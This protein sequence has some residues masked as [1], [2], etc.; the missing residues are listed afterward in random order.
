M[1]EQ[2]KNIFDDYEV[3]NFG[4]LRRKLLTGDYKIINCSIMNRGYKYFQ[5]RRQKKRINC[6]IHVLVAKHFLGEKPEQLVIDHID[7]NKLNNN[8]S[9]LRY[10]SQKVNSFN[11]DRVNQ[12]IEQDDPERKAKISKIYRDN[13]QDILKEKKRNYY[14]K[15]KEQIL[16]K[17]KN[18]KINVICPNCK[19]EREI[20]KTSRRT[21]KSDLCRPCS[22]TK[23]L[24][25]VSSTPQ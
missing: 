4:N 11:Q 5:I 19:T 2:Y 14:L 8:A 13:N 10:V 18:D 6:M 22:A 1:E 9:N 17:A 24:K 7:R 21:S 20:T 16:E 3:S 25:K 12:S 23:N 15:N